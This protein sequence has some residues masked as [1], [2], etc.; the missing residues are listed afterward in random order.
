[1]RG[2]RRVYALPMSLIMAS[3]CVKVTTWPAAM[4]SCTQTSAV[5]YRLGGVGSDVGDLFDGL[6]FH[7]AIADGCSWCG[8]ANNGLPFRGGYEETVGGGSHHDTAVEDTAA[9]M[10]VCVPLCEGSR[11]YP[12][13]LRK[14][15]ASGVWMLGEIPVHS[16][17]MQEGRGTVGARR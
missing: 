12:N 1:M 8:W 15:R 9:Q 3:C 4:M 11:D 13:R 16:L 7:V 10:F 5:R 17:V 6:C 2:I 14:G